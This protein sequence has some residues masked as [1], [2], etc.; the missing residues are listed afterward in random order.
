LPGRYFS[1]QPQAMLQP[2]SES[3]TRALF[4]PA[5]TGDVAAR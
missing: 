4:Q 3:L 2:V 5:Y 1:P